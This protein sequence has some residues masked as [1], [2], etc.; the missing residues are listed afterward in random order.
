MMM[1]LARWFACLITA[2]LVPSAAWASNFQDLWWNPAESGWGIN[3][4]QQGNT[5]FAT[6]FIYGANREPL[7][8][9]M[10][11]AVRSSAAT[12]EA[13]FTG[14]LFQTRG[15]PF[16]VAPFVPLASADVVSVGS[17]TFRFTDGKQGTLTYTINGQTV[18][19][20]ITRQNIVPI[21]LSGTY[22]GG[23]RRDSTGCTNNQNN[24]SRLEQA[25]YLVTT[26][27]QSTVINIAEVG[28]ENCRFSGTFTQH[29][30]TFEASGTY[31]CT[32]ITG[33]WTAREGTLT[34]TTFSMRLQ[35][36]QN[37]ETCQ[38]IGTLGGFKP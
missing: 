16:N 30:S 6:W 9:V 2:L 17:A 14:S 12:S 20:N 15:T 37:G 28:G 26:P 13:V 11:G 33:T 10:P 31:T 38:T 24:G 25:V 21:D 8:V 32:G 34:A 18:N 29:G 4:A 27:P 19:K 1:K 36:G 22:Y 35:L 5:L 3:I 23:F 7:W